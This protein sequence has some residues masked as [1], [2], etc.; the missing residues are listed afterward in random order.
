MEGN[1]FLKAMT[2]A[3]ETYESGGSIKK[4]NGLLNCIGAL[5]RNNEKPRSI[6]KQLTAKCELQ[7]NCWA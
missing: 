2:Q 5:Q 1:A 7:R 4:D 3:F 6:K